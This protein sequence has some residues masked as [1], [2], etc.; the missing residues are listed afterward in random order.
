MVDFADDPFEYVALI[1]CISAIL[2]IPLGPLLFPHFW[3]LL[4][5]AYFLTFL[6]TQFNHLYTFWLTYNK[7]KDTISP[8]DKLDDVEKTFINETDLI[9]AFVIPNYS[10]PEALLRDT[11]GRIALHR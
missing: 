11:I 4:L 10:E 2:M 3:I 5:S 1:V 8:D 7:I 9:H 6:G